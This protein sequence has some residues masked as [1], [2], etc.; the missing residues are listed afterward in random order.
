MFAAACGLVATVPCLS[1]VNCRAACGRER[2]AA[3]T[4]KKREA[5][6]RASSRYLRPGGHKLDIFERRVLSYLRHA[7]RKIIAAQNDD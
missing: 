6:A 4:L 2:V 1:Q 7:L 5:G 3:D